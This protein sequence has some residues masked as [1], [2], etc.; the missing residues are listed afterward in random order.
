MFLPVWGGDGWRK[1]GFTVSPLKMTAAICS[2]GHAQLKET[3][4]REEHVCKIAALIISSI[5]HTSE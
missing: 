2:C 1:R 5:Y 3:F 4:F